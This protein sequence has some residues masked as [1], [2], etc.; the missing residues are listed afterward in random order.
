M[1]N[2]VVVTFAH[3]CYILVIAGDV[4]YGIKSVLL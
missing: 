3:T 1:G 2:Y 4:S